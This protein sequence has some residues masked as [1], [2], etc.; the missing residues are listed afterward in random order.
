MAPA[1]I[2]FLGFAALGI[3]DG[4]RVRR[5]GRIIDGRS[6]GWQFLWILG[7][8]IILNLLGSVTLTSPAQAWFALGAGVLVA[9]YS[10]PPSRRL[11]ASPPR[12][13]PSSYAC[14]RMLATSRSTSASSP[15][16]GPGPGSG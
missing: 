7:F 16:G 3:I 11:S 13:C 4:Q 10:S 8:L 15:S 12:R 9:V 5:R 2:F 1:L 14:W 6:I